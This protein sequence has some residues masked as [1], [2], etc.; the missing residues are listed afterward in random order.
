MKRHMITGADFR[1]FRRQ[2]R[3]LTPDAIA[4]LVASIEAAF[5]AAAGAELLGDDDVIVAILRKAWM[6]EAQRVAFNVIR[7]CIAYREA[8]AGAKDQWLDN[9]EHALYD[10]EVTR[11]AG[12]AQ[13]RGQSKGGRKTAIANRAEAAQRD[14]KLHAAAKMILATDGPMKDAAL[15]AI[16]AERGHGGRETIRKKLPKLLRR[17]ESVDRR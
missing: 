11:V 16:L 8:N 4:P 17:K 10:A 14:R 13:M 6:T 3:G 1:A 12:A 7:M 9:L 15:A 5:R 2:R